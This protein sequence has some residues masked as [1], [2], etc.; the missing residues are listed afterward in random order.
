MGSCIS[1][2]R[3]KKVPQK[4]TSLEECGHVQDKLV[5][6]PA[7]T[8][9][10]TPSPLSYKVSPSQS[11]SP[12]TSSFSSFSGSTTNTASS[13][14]LSSSATSSISSAKDK[15]FSN[16]FLW[17]CVKENPHILQK[18]APLDLPAR[19]VVVAQAKQLVPERVAAGSALQKRARASSPSTL[20]R[21][22]SFRREPDRPESTFSRS[23]SP[24]TLSRHRSF[25]R[26][27]SRPDSTFTRPCSPSSTTLT[28]QRSFRREPDRPDSMHYIPSR[29]LRSPSP[30]RRF[31]GDKCRGLLSNTP[32]EN[33]YGKRWIDL[34]ASAVNSVS[35]P[36]TSKK[37]VAHASPK[38]SISSTGSCL[39]KT[40][41]HHI[42]SEIGVGE[43]MLSSQDIMDSVPAEDVDNPLISLDCF[44]FL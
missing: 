17:S 22:K 1:K 6:S 29:A 2:C 21:Q 15:A 30:S 20:T 42:G 26:E 31:N 5:I 14:S 13:C 33:S 10:T 44:I 3:P 25:R 40:Y 39:R 32:K 36:Y 34:K 27:P 7:P 11:P 4:I 43:E 41:A 23:S 16:E 12:C 8:I 9:C 24:S 28:R 18:R 37:H 35:S 19:S 38:S